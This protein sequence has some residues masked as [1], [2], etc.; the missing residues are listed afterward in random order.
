M[1]EN[2]PAKP[3]APKPLN[4]F[5]TQQDRKRYQHVLDQGGR[6]T[7]IPMIFLLQAS[8]E[9]VKV[10]GSTFKAGEFT[11]GPQKEVLGTSFLAVVGPWRPHARHTLNGQIVAESFDENDKVFHAVA[12]RELELKG[13]NTRTEFANVGADFLL[14]VPKQAQFGTFFLRGAAK[15]DGEQAFDQQGHPVTIASKYVSSSNG[16]YVPTFKLWTDAVPQDLVLPNAVDIEHAERL[17]TNP[18]AMA[19]PAATANPKHD[20]RP[21]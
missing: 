20:A 12:D 1:P 15:T 9:I 4:L 13:T 5:K 3:N 17:F 11:F 8:S 6:T 18:V 2:V 16:Y 19:K 14:W 21:R 7:F 10:P